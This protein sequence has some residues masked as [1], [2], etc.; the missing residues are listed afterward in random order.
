MSVPTFLVLAIAPAW[1][2][3]KS[4]SLSGPR[5]TSTPGPLAGPRPHEPVVVFNDRPRTDTEN[6]IVN[7]HQGS[8]KRFRGVPGGA[9]DRFWWVGS[10]WVPCEEDK[11]LA[12]G[13]GD[14]HEKMVWG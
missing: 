11:T 13:C 12:S 5:G 4:T 10:A 6:R 2:S 8:I 1:Q 7:A 3:T 9:T 14:H